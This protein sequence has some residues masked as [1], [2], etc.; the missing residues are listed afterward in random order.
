MLIPEIIKAGLGVRESLFFL[1]LLSLPPSFVQLCYTEQEE[2]NRG[3]KAHT[4]ISLVYYSNRPDV[5]SQHP[6]AG[7]MIQGPGGPPQQ[8]YQGPPQ[9]Y[10]PPQGAPPPQAQGGLQYK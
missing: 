5:Q 4:E 6:G 2:D 1:Y 3:I 7:N 9:G 8:G 10:Q